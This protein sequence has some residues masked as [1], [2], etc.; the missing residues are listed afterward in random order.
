[1]ATVMKSAF[2]LLSGQAKKEELAEELS[3]KLYGGKED[4]ESMKELGI[5]LVKKGGAPLHPESAGGGADS[6]QTSQTAQ[7]GQTTKA[8]ADDQ[9]KP[10]SATD[11]IRKA[12]LGRFWAKAVMNPEL[13][14]IPMVLIGMVVVQRIRR[15]R[16]PADEFM[17]PD[18]SATLPSADTENYTMKHAVHALS[19][20]DFE[21]LVARIYQRQGYRVEMPSG[22]SSGRGGD[23]TLLRKSERLLVQCKKLGPEQKVGVE[24][25]R[26]LHDALVPAKATR[27]VY[28]ACCGFSWDARN[29]AK[30]KGMT[31]INAR[32]LDALLTVTGRLGMGSEIH[33]QSE[34]HP[35]DLSGL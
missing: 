5:E 9:S 2:R 18:L 14:L 35:A 34:A 22:V 21:L 29:F 4:Q 7:A 25:V 27:G 23:F 8:V 13:S 24:R 16:S 30:A 17:L 3:D 10:E 33:E 11:K 20:E 6:R 28:I 26:E 15:R 19:S 1:M 32:A 12:M 31:L